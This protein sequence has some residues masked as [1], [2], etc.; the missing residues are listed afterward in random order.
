[1]R[2]VGRSFLSD[3]ICPACYTELDLRPWDR[4]VTIGAPPGVA[5]GV[6]MDILERLRSSG[7]GGTLVPI[8][9]I[10]I[11]LLIVVLVAWGG[12]VSVVRLRRHG[13]LGPGIGPI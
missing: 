7:F 10:V 1:M 3:I 12:W 2:A 6:G 11:L 9:V 8:T 13:A 4:F 5:I